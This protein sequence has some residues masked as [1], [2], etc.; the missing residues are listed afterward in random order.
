MGRKYSDWAL[1]AGEFSGEFA[2]K[3][4][5]AALNLRRKNRGR[6]FPQV[7]F[8]RRSG[9]LPRVDGGLHASQLTRYAGQV[10]RMTNEQ[11]A[12]RCEVMDEP[13]N[14]FPLGVGVEINQNVAAEDHVKRPSDLIR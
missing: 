7:G 1:I 4:P 11:K 8:A 10:F 2:R 9:F 3:R 13:R 6:T 5:S 14:N 12:I